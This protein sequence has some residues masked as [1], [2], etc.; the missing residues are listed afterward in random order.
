MRKAIGIA[1]STFVLSTFLNMFFQNAMPDYIWI[2][3]GINCNL[4]FISFFIGIECIRKE[5]L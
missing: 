4:F 5:R 3:L 1:L 2:Y